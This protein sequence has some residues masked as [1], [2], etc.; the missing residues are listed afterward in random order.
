[1]GEE[2]FEEG[3]PVE[4]YVRELDD[5]VI[6]EE[7]SSQATQRLEDI[8]EPPIKNE[9]KKPIVAAVEPKKDPTPE[10]PKP[11][12]KPVAPKI[13]IIPSVPPNGE[14]PLPPPPLEEENN[15][16]AFPSLDGLISKA[17]ERQKE[18]I[19]KKA[20]SDADQFEQRFYNGLVALV[21]SVASGSVVPLP[22]QS[23]PQLPPPQPPQEQLI[24]MIHPSDEALKE[25][26]GIDLKLMDENYVGSPSKMALLSRKRFLQGRPLTDDDLKMYVPSSPVNSKKLDSKTIGKTKLVE[27]QAEGIKKPTSVKVLLAG[28]LASFFGVVLLVVSLALAHLI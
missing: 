26:N 4:E 11:T 18:E 10:V 17:V 13:P 22:Q 3:K 6:P 15:G 16:S 20:K 24:N 2:N 21:E 1:M 23:V 8:I 25:I 12:Q 9:K 19:F 5:L 28:G 7:P 14:Q 27:E